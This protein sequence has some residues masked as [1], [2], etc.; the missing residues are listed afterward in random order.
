MHLPLKRLLPPQPSFADLLPQG[1]RG[2]SPRIHFILTP[3]S[4]H[5]GD[6]AAALARVPVSRETCSRLDLY[7]ELL[8]RWRKVTNLV[9][10]STF[11]RV[12]TRHIADSAQLLDLA[13]EA[14]TWLDIG[15]GAGFPGLVLAA[16]LAE[17]PGAHVHLVESDGR[18]CAFLREAARAMKA[19]ARV[20]MRRIES[21]DLDELGPVDAVVARA[22]APL[23][24]L[25]LY[26]K[27][28]LAGDAVGLFPRGR[29][30]RHPDDLGLDPNFDYRR[31]E[32]RMDPQAGIV[33][34]RRAAPP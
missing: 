16:R 21:F 4:S 25:V 12:W 17:T 15:S 23:P 5:S 7:V 6:R 33:V 34:V 22:V 20:W 14:K 24:Q 10:E 26:A 18:K 13:P 8:A 3:H 28:W 30:D 32:S 11:A 19:P 9:G 31:L 2:S 29:N 1:K 27:P